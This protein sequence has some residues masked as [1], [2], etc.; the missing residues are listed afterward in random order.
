MPQGLTSKATHNFLCGYF[1]KKKTWPYI[2]A[3]AVFD[4]NKQPE[5]SFIPADNYSL[6]SDNK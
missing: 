2:R 1:R 3:Y 6:Q 5:G 4:A